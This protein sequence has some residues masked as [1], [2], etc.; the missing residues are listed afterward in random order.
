MPKIS[1][2]MSAYN[3]E[4]YLEEAIESI[5]A[6]TFSDFEFIII[7]DGSTDNTAEILSRYRDKRIKV[8]DQK[9]TGLAVALNNG[10]KISTT[11]YIARMDADDV[12]LS[13][14]LEKQF[15]FLENNSDHI[16]VGSNAEV[17][18]K[19]GKFVFNSNLPLSDI[20]IRIKLPEIS[21]FHPAV[22]F[23]K[24]AFYCAGEYSTCMLR[25]QDYILFNRMHKYG[26]MANLSNI[27]IRYR[28]V[29]SANTL[30]D[31][32]HSKK[33]YEILDRAIEFNKITEEDFLYLKE[34]SRKRHSRKRIQDYYYYVG[35]K[36]LWNNYQPKLAVKNFILALK[37]NPFNTRIIVYFLFSLMPHSVIKSAYNKYKK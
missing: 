21:F 34:I 13:D 15:D 3:A 29:P 22:M 16:I 20:E 24:T 1:V 23:K 11:N 32:K 8:I 28:I 35:T 9:N 36:Y 31:N 17:M 30:R 18:D 14:R 7:N 37:I 6:Q 4:N 2:V 5:L 33:Y 12:C 19:D 10:I 25:G 27:L 26:K